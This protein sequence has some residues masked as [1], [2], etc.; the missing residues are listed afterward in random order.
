MLGSVFDAEDAA[1][2]TFIRAWRALSQFDGRSSLRTWLYRIATNVCLDHLESRR[3]RIRPTEVGSPCNSPSES[4][5]TTQPAETWIEPIPDVDAIPSSE[6]PAH[7]AILRES[8]RLAF[9]AAL[10]RLPPKQRAVLLLNDVLDFSSAE[11]AS[12]LSLSVAAVNSALQRARETMGKPFDASSADLTTPQE[13]TVRHYVEA[14]ERYDIPAITSMLRADVAFC[15][16]PYSLWLQGPNAV[17]SWMQTFGAGCRG[18]RLLPARA[19]ASPAFA[20]FR[21]D[22]A[23]GHKAWGL[24]VLELAGDQIATITTFLDAER[25]FPRFGLPLTLPANT[26]S[27]DR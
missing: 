24:I 19:S 3:R 21:Q 15:M 22:A 23:G 12:A 11:T 7:R 9:I 6:D 14:F 26:T 13:Q 2:D 25:L 20:Q 10:Q 16:P 8:V 17:S 27:A 4:D 5:L 1:Q 18:S